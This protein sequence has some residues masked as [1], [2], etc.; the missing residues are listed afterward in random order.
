MG[1]T[2]TRFPVSKFDLFELEELHDD[3]DDVIDEGVII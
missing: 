3:G 2:S 1:T